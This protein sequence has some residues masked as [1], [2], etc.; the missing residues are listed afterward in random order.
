MSNSIVLCLVGSL[1]LRLGNAATAS[2]MSLLLAM[3]QRQ[4]ADVTA[5]T[6]AVLAAA[7]Y[8]T[9]LLGAPWFGVQSDLRGRRPFMIVGP[10]FGAIAIQLIGW[11]R[12]IALMVV[13]R[14][15]EGLSTASTAP[16]TLSYLSAATSQL[17]ATRARIMAWYEM[18][19]VVGIAGGFAAGGL[20]W[21]RL[22]EGAFVAVT[23]IYAGSFGAFWLVRDVRSE[24]PTASQ[25]TMG[26]EE[27]SE[28]SGIMPVLRRPRIL[29]F[30]PAW[31]AVNTILGAWFI[32]S[33]LLL[34]G[35]MR[36]GQYLTGVMGGTG[37]S[38]VFALMGGAFLVGIYLWGMWMG[39]RRRT[40]VMLATLPGI[41]IVCAGVWA[42]N[43]LSGGEAPRVALFTSVLVLGIVIA[44]GFTPAALA[45]LADLS[46]EA[47]HL[48]G[49][50]MGLYSVMLG[51]GQLAGGAI[52]GPFATAS[53]IDGLILLTALLGTCASAVVLVLR[54]SESALSPPGI[55]A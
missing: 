22:G 32:H 35:Q 25:Q 14:F 44:S 13:G 20:L 52:G 42:L 30:A 16:S 41:Y 45:F 34:T 26:P 46:E 21:D 48:R 6:L 43:H 9:E 18:A 27:S 10:I 47:A 53:G 23:A 51:L 12:A 29:R 4:G 24:E 31:L 2:L 37:V 28:H 19:T 8:V 5:N 38:L 33:T 55:A 40:T 36:E 50:I 17:A 7:F 1:L 49:A 15:I 11:P 3:L 54:R 39:A